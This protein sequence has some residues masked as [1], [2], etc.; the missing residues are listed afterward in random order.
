MKGKSSMSTTTSMP[1][2]GK[3]AERP[4]RETANPMNKG[5]CDLSMPKE[6]KAAESGRMGK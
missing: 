1:K 2:E 5:Y 6:G 4:G 3:A